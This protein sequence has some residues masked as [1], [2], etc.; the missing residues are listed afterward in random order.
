MDQHVCFQI[1]HFLASV[2][3]VNYMC[4][5]AS[6]LACCMCAVDGKWKRLWWDTSCENVQPLTF[7]ERFDSDVSPTLK[8]H[9]FEM[10]P[11]DNL[12]SVTAHCGECHVK[13][14]GIFLLLSW[15]L[16]L[17]HFYSGLTLSATCKVTLCSVQCY[18][19]FNILYMLLLLPVL[20]WAVCIVWCLL[21]YCSYCLYLCCLCSHM[22]K[23]S[24]SS[25]CTKMSDCV[26]PL[27]YNAGRTKRRHMFRG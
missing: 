10:K 3:C 25:Y 19:L 15:F 13:V 6:E 1:L 8:S 18:S 16:F 22:P 27:K 26:A 12:P 20:Y 17:A 23:D 2:L 4:I 11:L 21:L 14:S 5:H 24:L 7:K 9:F